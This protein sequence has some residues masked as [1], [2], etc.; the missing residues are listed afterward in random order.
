MKSLRF[1]PWDYNDRSAN[2][3]KKHFGGLFIKRKGSQFVPDKNTVVINWGTLSA[4]NYPYPILNRDTSVSS[5][6][7]ATFSILTLKNIPCVDITTHK[8]IADAWLEHGFTVLARTANQFG[9]KGIQIFDGTQDTPMYSK[10]EKKAK[11][12]RVHVMNG[13]AFWVQQ[14]KGKKGVKKDPLIWSHN[15]G[16]C[17]VINNIDPYPQE[18]TD[19]AVQAT[20]ALKLDFAA[21]DILQNTK[22]EWKIIEC[23]SAPGIENT[24]LKKYI[25]AFSANYQ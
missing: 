5:N 25:E 22:G 20:K 6:K 15:R 13:K 8:K 3:L 4:K 9:G 23:N 10:V 11:E 14:K 24:T 2:E 7:L 16:Y 19:L 1:M 17:F 12:Y 21:L 18:L